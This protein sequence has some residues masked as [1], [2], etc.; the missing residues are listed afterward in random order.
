MKKVLILI[1]TFIIALLLYV[2]LD[3]GNNSKPINLHTDILDKSTRTTPKIPLITPANNINEHPVI[4][5]EEENYLKNQSY[6]I[7][8]ELDIDDIASDMAPI[9]DVSPI[10]ALRMKQ[11]TIKEIEI[12]D[13]I[14]LPSIEGISYELSIT[15]KEVS[16]RGNVSIDGS[17]SENGVKYTAILTEGSNAAF[18]SMN[19]PEGTYEIEL[20]NG[21]GYVYANSDIDKAKIDY[22]KTDEVKVHGEEH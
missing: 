1:T 10:S 5:I 7:F 17:F 2:W 11:G 4:H 22:T 14:L 16:S 13:S 21:I 20:L 9:A 15:H 6:A 18:I 8:E 3:E 19:T 12:G